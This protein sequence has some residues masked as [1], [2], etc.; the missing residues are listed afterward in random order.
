MVHERIQD[1]EPL[2]Q[3]ESR[4]GEFSGHVVNG[5]SAETKCDSIDIDGLRSE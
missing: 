4:P 1:V 3:R 2:A 5:F